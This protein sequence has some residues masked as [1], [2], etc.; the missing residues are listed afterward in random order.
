MDINI[1]GNHYDTQS[2]LYAQVF[3]GEDINQN[4]L[5]SL[6]DHTTSN[7]HLH[8]QLPTPPRR[9]FTIQ[10][11]LQ[12]RPSPEECKNLERIFITHNIRNFPIPLSF[13]I[14]CTHPEALA[15]AESAAAEIIDNYHTKWKILSANLAPTATLHVAVDIPYPMFAVPRALEEIS[16]ESVFAFLV[17]PRFRRTRVRQDG[18]LL[19]AYRK[20]YVEDVRMSAMEEFYRWDPTLLTNVIERFAEGER[21]AARDVAVRVRAALV[22][23]MEA[24]EVYVKD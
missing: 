5:F 23:I 16:T 8:E 11:L 6:D 18:E 24:T 2:V 14:L 20:A 17:H 15:L 7:F 21:K 4:T 3:S 10:D 12:R 13:S 1:Q 9:N 22:G 19:S